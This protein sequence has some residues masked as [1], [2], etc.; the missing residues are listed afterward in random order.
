M[1]TVASSLL[2][3]LTGCGSVR[4]HPFCL[5]VLVC[6]CR[7]LRHLPLCIPAPFH[8]WRWIHFYHRKSFPR[9][10]MMTGTIQVC[11]PLL[12]SSKVVEKVDLW[13]IY[14]C[15]RPIGNCYAFMWW[16]KNWSFQPDPV[17]F[18]NVVIVC[19]WII[20]DHDGLFLVVEERH[21]DHLWFL[22][23]SLH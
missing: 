20:S 10:L 5:W 22:G 9:S 14:L 13:H 23:S 17:R 7:W 19:A 16:L 11:L 4:A 6:L 18:T 15:S 3:V 1:F 8:K 21:H 12:S 2:F